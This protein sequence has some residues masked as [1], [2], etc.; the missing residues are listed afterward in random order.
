MGLYHN[1]TH[2]NYNLDVGEGEYVAWIRY[3]FG[4]YVLD[5]ICKV[6]TLYDDFSADLEIVASKHMTQGTML[7]KQSLREFKRVKLTPIDDDLKYTASV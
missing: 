4:E 3:P 5:P 6:I 7:V 2:W 1:I